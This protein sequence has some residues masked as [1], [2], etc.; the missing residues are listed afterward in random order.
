MFIKVEFSD[1]GLF[2]NHT[3]EDVDR[4]ASAANFTTLLGYALSVEY[5]DAEVEIE[6]TINDVHRV[7]GQTDT[8]EAENV[9]NIINRVWESWEWLDGSEAD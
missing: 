6:H 3:A 5:P 1:D 4:K 9:G 7:D 8:V 2:G